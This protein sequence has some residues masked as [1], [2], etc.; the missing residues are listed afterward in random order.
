LDA[1]AAAAAASPDDWDSTVSE[2]RLSAPTFDFDFD[3]SEID[4]GGSVAQGDVNH[5]LQP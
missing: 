4:T 5:A 3:S 2:A 1:A